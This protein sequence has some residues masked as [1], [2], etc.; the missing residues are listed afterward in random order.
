M[1]AR[2]L[3]FLVPGDL[4]TIT[5]GYGYDRRLIAG[6]RAL[7]WQVA[8]HSLDPGFPH[9][10]APALEHAARLL[11]QLQDGARVLIDGL[12]LGA[13]PEVIR[14][15]SA[16]L[17]L[18]AL[19]HHPLAAETGLEP[20]D[21]HAL[22]CAERRALQAVRHVLV[23]SAATRHA[24]HAYGV[25][26]E[27]ISVLEPGTDPA[28]LA[29]P[30]PRGE[31]DQ[32]APPAHLG[33]GPL[34]QPGDGATLRLL[35]VATLIPRKGHDVLFEALAPLAPL[36][37]HLTC[38]GSLTRDHS[39]AARLRSQLERLGLTGRVT[40][41]GEVDA[42]ALA[43]HLQSADLFVLPTR[44]EGYGMAVAEALA[45]G[46]PVISTP[47]GGIAGLIGTDAGLLVPPDDADALRVA[48]TRVLCEPQLRVRLARGAAAARLK[49]PRWQHTCERLSQI[50]EQLGAQPA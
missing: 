13:M 6:L 10:S 28:P 50:L 30:D 39:T 16:R 22:G 3:E 47:T 40:L 12:A 43:G 48:L 46:L 32:G 1:S 18:L 2:T 45:H 4:E 37:W 11:A 14:P 7:G 31:L 8:V 38:V 9:P 49:L 23:T 27:R 20:G 33:D 29:Q 5:G 15:H 19:V 24:L 26:P 36:H 34:R 21:A 41:A 44:F 17:A 42:A 35:C 25:A